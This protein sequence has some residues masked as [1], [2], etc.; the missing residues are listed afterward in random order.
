MSET[1]RADRSFHLIGAVPDRLE[2][3]PVARRRCWSDEFK[4][5]TVA[6]SLEPVANVSALA[7]EIGILPSQLFGWRSK[8]AGR[9]KVKRVSTSATG[10]GTADGTA[11]EVFVDG[12]LVRVGADVDEDHLRRVLRAV[13]SA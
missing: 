10:T 1:M 5:A 9:G 3:A 7:R 6:R 4:A 12:M 11:I 8:A 13:R 2:G